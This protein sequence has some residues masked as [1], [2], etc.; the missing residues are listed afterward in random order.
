MCAELVCSGE[1]IMSFI[2]KLALQM[3]VLFVLLLAA[4]AA[5]RFGDRTLQAWSPGQQLSAQVCSA[6]GRNRCTVPISA[7]LKAQTYS[8]ASL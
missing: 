7:N 8:E 4:V 2:S 1:K 5:S 6:E 3:L